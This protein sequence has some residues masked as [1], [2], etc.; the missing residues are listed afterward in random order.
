MQGVQG[1]QGDS[2]S[3]LGAW[4]GGT[5]YSTLQTVS[6]GGSSWVSLVNNNTGNQPDTSP[7][8]WSLV[9]QKGD[10]GDKGDQGDQGIQGI[11]GV[12]GVK[13]D[14]GDKGDTGDQGPPGPS[15]AGK[16]VFVSK[17]TFNLNNGGASNQWF[18]PIHI[19][20]ANSESWEVVGMVPLPCKIGRAHV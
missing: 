20:E 6:F 16:M 15:G 2:V 18:S 17:H 4:D 8:Q 14:K 5:T 1:P 11:Q 9:A 12:Q 19:E 13:G 10:K 3:F 7:T